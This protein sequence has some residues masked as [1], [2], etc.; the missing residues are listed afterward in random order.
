LWWHGPK[1]LA[2][3]HNAWPVGQP[4]AEDTSPVRDERQSEQRVTVGVTAHVECNSIGPERYGCVERLFRI[5]AYCQRFVR[6]CR[7][8]AVPR[9]GGALTVAELRK[10]EGTWV[11]MAQSE[12]FSSELQALSRKGRVVAT[13]RLS[14]LDPF[15]DEE[16]FLRVGGRLENAELPPHMKHPVILPGDHALTMG[17]IRRCHARQMHAGTTHTLAILRQQYWV[18]KG[19][20]QVKKVIRHCFACRRAMARPIQPRMAALPSSR[21]V[22][23]AAFAHTGMDFAGPLL[24]RVGKG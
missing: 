15:L 17:L 14:R 23:A 10:A 8:P 4:I 2:H 13:S 9:Q 12:A 1:W 6:N 3:P 24:I 11:R 22:E 7:L 5:T 20:T 18:L 19:R 16:G 21:V